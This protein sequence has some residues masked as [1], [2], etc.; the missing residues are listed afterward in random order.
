MVSWESLTI[1]ATVR[2]V[3]QG[4][5]LVRAI[6]ALGTIEPSGPFERAIAGLLLAAYKRGIVEAAP[7]W[8]AEE[9]LSASQHIGEDRAAVWMSEN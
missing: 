8:V 9:I 6:E 2:I 4:H 3:V 1:D 7:S 5:A